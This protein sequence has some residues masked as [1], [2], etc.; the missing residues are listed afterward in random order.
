MERLKEVDLHRKTKTY[1]INIDEKWTGSKSSISKKNTRAQVGRSPFKLTDTKASNIKKW[2]QGKRV[3]CKGSLSLVNLIEK[4]E[5]KWKDCKIELA[6]RKVKEIE[7][8]KVET[9]KIKIKS[10][11]FNKKNRRRKKEENLRISKVN[12]EK[13]A[14]LL[15]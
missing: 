13:K 9:I 2:R 8:G 14:T 10:S 15:R 5:R 12:S 11:K 6:I 4:V 1:G 7:R 3:S